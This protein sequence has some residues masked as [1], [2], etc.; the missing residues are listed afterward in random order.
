MHG[1]SNTLVEELLSLLRLDLFPKDN[2][3]P[4]SLYEAKTI[5]KKL[6]LSTIQ[7]MHVI[8][9]VYCLKENCRKPKLVQS[10]KG[11]CL[12]NGQLLF[13]ARCFIIFY[14]S[15]A[16]YNTYKCL[17]LVN[18]M[19]S[20]HN[21]KKNNDGL[22][23]FICDSKAWK[24]IDMTRLNFVT[25]IH[26]I[27]KLGVTLDGVNRYV[28]LFKNNSTWPCLHLNYNL[29]PWLTTKWFFMILTLLM[30]GKE[31]IKNENVDMYM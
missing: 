28:D 8:M 27:L 9:D 21:A 2:T 17:A 18:L 26:N 11:P 23:C 3:I 4:K 1:V 25:N 15:Q 31:S 30:Q 12:L 29:P 16:S 14:Q 7:F 19:K 10:V 20:W 5:L 6:K 13:L 24:H 22:V